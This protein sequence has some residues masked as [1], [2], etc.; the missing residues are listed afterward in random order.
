MIHDFPAVR[1]DDAT[2]IEEFRE[3]GFS[4]AITRKELEY[5]VLKMAGWMKS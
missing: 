5:K 1:P 4:N 2:A 3:D